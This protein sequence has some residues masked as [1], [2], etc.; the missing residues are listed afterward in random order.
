[1]RE[2]VLRDLASQ[3]AKDPA[4]LRRA[5]TDLRGALASHGYRLNIFELGLVEGLVRQ[6]AGMS[7]QEVVRMLAGGLTERSSGA[8]A[9][10]TPPRGRGAGPAR[11][12][13]PGG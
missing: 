13:R 8:P 11:P 7:D 9:S 2:K 12:S 3:A 10:P 1:M 5:R 4:F 6:T